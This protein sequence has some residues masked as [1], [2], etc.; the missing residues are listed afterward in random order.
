[1]MVN[2]IHRKCCKNNSVNCQINSSQR[3][4]EYNIPVPSA[5]IITFRCI[6]RCKSI[7]QLESF[8]HIT[9][10]LFIILL[11]MNCFLIIILF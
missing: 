5:G 4:I 9:Q 1:M 8:F 10:S 11:N 3:E 6:F 7:V 2:V